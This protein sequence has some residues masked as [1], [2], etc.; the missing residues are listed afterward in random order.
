[1]SDNK[2]NDLFERLKYTLTL[3]RT[4]VIIYIAAVLWVAVATQMIMNRIFVNE[5]QITEAFVKSDTSQMQSSLE[6]AAEYKTDFLSEEAKKNM[7]YDLADAIGLIIDKDITILNEAKRE[8]Y[9]FEK[10][11]KH[12]Y[13][14]I[15]LISMEEEEGETVKVKHY[16]LVRL[17]VQEGIK[18]IDQYKKSLEKAFDA[19]G[20]KHRQLTLKYEGN[21]KGNLTAKQKKD[22]ASN[23][24]DE[25][26]GEIALEYD[27]GDLYTVYAYTGMLKEYVTSLG[28]KINVQIAITYNEINNKTTI[29]LAT[30]I[31]NESW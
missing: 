14:E 27:E 29:T 18:S 7:I 23:L 15:K 5:L 21:R 26:Q 1:M 11:A 2:W 20:I 25:L 12:A 16:V 6:I 8:E 30:P 10:Q 24:V 28:N 3:K 22:I 9:S 19:L 4:R 13:S 31:L 17:N